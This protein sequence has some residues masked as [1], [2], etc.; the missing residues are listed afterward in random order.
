MC[1]SDYVRQSVKRFYPSLEEQDLVTLLARLRDEA[2]DPEARIELGKRCAR[3]LE[4]ELHDDLLPATRR[5][6]TDVRRQLE[7]AAA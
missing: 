6:E 7:G 4:V 1:L 3:I 2:G 5:H